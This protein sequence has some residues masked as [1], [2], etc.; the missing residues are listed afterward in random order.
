MAAR[1]PSLAALRNAA[2][3]LIRQAG[4]RYI[5]DARRFLPS[6]PDFGLSWLFHPPSLEN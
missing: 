1:L 3:N 5:P 4:L 6:T 2:I